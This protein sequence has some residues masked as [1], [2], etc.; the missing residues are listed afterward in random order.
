MIINTGGR[1]DTVQHYTEWLL[2]R[3]SEGYVL[4]RNPLFPNKVT[5]YEL[6]PDKVDCV[7]FCSK[8]YS[9]ILPRL[10]EITDPR[11]IIARARDRCNLVWLENLNLRGSFK[12]DIIAYI[13]DRHPE[14]LPLYRRIYTER[15]MGYWEDLDAEMAEFCRETGL[16]YVVNDDSMERPFE[17]PPIVVNFFY[18]ERIRRSAGGDA[19]CRSCLR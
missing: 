5:R 2:N 14:L 15:D 1:T 13:S 19:R 6:T 8:D 16:E 3:F 4:S 9:P 10:H 17:D 7:V 12:S 18:H 11:E